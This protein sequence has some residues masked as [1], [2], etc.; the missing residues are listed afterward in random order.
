MSGR[1]WNAAPSG[2]R[3]RNGYLEGVG[4]WDLL[5]RVQVRIGEVDIVHRG[6]AFLGLLLLPTAVDL[7]L[8]QAFW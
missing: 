7:H 1:A 5:E 4:Q 6:G 8:V 2:G 3:A